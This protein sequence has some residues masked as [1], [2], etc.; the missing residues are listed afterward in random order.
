VGG[1]TN[2][3]TEIFIAY[4]FEAHDISIICSNEQL[5]LNRNAFHIFIY[6]YFELS[7]LFFQ[8]NQASDLI[9][10]L[11]YPLKVF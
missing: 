8:L 2:K 3:K 1:E 4:T 9:I 7:R 11:F 5:L 6:A 10:D